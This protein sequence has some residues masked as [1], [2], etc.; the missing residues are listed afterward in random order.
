MVH[1]STQVRDSNNKIYTDANGNN[2]DRFDTTLDVG[3]NAAMAIEKECI[4]I[5]NFMEAIST[6]NKIIISV[7]IHDSISGTYPVYYSYYG[8][9]KRFIK[10][11]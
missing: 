7:M 3:I 4:R 9:E 1:L 2:Q 8:S 5:F 6:S 11:N 10:H